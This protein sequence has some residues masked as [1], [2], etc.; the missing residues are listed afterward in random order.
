MSTPVLTEEELN[1]YASLDLADPDDAAL[2][3]F[4]HDARPSH[5]PHEEQRA[6]KPSASSSSSSLAASPDAA[7]RRRLSSSVVTCSAAARP[8]PSSA[9]AAAADTAT[10]GVRAPRGSRYGVTDVLDKSDLV[11][12]VAGMVDAALQTRIVELPGRQLTSLASIQCFLNATHLYLQH[13]DIR[14][15]EGLEM[16][17][18]LQ[19]LVVH[20]NAITSAAPLRHLDRLFYLDLG[21]NKLDALST[22]LATELPCG[23]LHYLNLTGNPCCR[24]GAAHDAYVTTVCAACPALA[25]LDDVPLPPD[26]EDETSDEATRTEGGEQAEGVGTEE[27]ERKGNGVAAPTEPGRDTSAGSSGGGRR[28]VKEIVEAVR[29]ATQAEHHPRKSEL[30]SAPDPTASNAP[31]NDGDVT[32][33]GTVVPPTS[34]EYATPLELE[35]ERLLRQLLRRSSNANAGVSTRDNDEEG[36]EEEGP[37][38]VAAPSDSLDALQLFQDLRYT[39]EVR[40]ARHQRDIA[41]YWDD[42]SRVLQTAKGLQQDRR[43]RLH[44]RLQEDTP[45]YTETL[46]LLQS[47]S[48]TKDLRCYREA[49]GSPH[50]SCQ[51]PQQQQPQQPSVPVARASTSPA[52]A[53]TTASNATSAKSSR[54]SLPKKNEEGPTHVPKPPPP[55]R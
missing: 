45:F 1:Y 14:S 40:Q 41:A 20:H 22:L 19:V 13:N 53:A 10:T 46:Q 15:V 9:T 33:N 43:R 36:G 34:S 3:T 48:Y 12:G 17:S 28:R 55:R 35:E 51:Q 2:R 42:V 50:W 18:R 52:T 23:S 21:H 37:A 31:I 54:S 39:Q 32:D 4:L 30:H 26:A 24:G 27:E 29:A 25:C 16:L 11:G 49:A 5:S 6:A 8:Q 44:E 7:R 47:E 38:V